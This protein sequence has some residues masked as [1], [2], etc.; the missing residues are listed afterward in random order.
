M[1]KGMLLKEKSHLEC[2][3]ESIDHILQG[4]DEMNFSV[5]SK[6][7]T[8]ELF[9]AMLDHMPENMEMDLQSF[10]CGQFRISIIINNMMRRS[11]QFIVA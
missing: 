1:Q 6:D 8:E 9:Q 2:L 11:C 4:T 5:F 10:W 3:I 7:E